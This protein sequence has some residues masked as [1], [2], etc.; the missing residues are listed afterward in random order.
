MTSQESRAKDVVL[1]GVSHM[2]LDFCALGMLVQ[3]GPGEG[4]TFQGLEAEHTRELSNLSLLLVPA[5][6]SLPTCRFLF[7]Y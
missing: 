1:R 5:L 4:V 2:W 6:G 3:G 7:C